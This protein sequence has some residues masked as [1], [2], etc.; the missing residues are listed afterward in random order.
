MNSLELLEDAGRVPLAILLYTG[1]R[2]GEVLALR[3]EKIDWK[4]RLIYVD[5]AVT[6]LN[7]QPVVGP[8]K[9][10]TGN[11]FIPLDDHLADV[12]R[13]FRQISGYVVGG[14]CESYDREDIYPDVAE[15]READQFIWRYAAYL[16]PYIYYPCVL[17][18]DRRQNA[19]RHRGPLGYQD[20]NGQI[21]PS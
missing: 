12:L 9:R 15:D 10:E 21:H 4:R 13:P 5:Q 2:R 3:W 17:F 19:A 18:W 14:W 20:D 1:M 16:S 7:N 6:F 8:T 11:R